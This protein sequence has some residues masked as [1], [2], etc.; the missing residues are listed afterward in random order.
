MGSLY[1]AVDRR[2]GGILGIIWTGIQHFGEM[3]GSE[4]AA[5]MAYYTLFSLFPLML[6]LVAAGSFLLNRQSVFQQV[7]DLV[8]SAIP[9]S[10]TL[11]EENLMQVLELRGP[12][13]LVGLGAAL[14]SGTGAF[15]VLTRNINRAWDQAQPRSVVKNR[16][17][18]LAMVGTLAV[19][20]ILLLLLSTGLNVLSSFEVHFIDLEIL[21][22]TRLWT[23]LTEFLPLVVTFVLFLALYRWVPNAEAHWKAAFWT[24]LVVALVWELASN[25]FVWYIGSG[26]VSYRLVYGSLGTLIALLFWIYL[27]SW[28]IIFGAHMSAAVGS[29]LRE[30]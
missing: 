29:Y 12:V 1:K 30:A 10:Q 11:I 2:T 15:T 8:G 27:S 24:A 13:G 19:L 7:V 21:Y 6:A 26:L 25:A 17:L 9:I 14:W 16:L 5:S 18:A 28:I 20:L 3:N 23:A 4:A 22:G